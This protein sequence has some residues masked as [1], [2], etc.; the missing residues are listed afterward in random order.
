MISIKIL[1]NIPFIWVLV[2]L[3]VL[4]LISGEFG[5]ILGRRTRT[6]LSDSKSIRI[7][8]TVTATLALLGF[9]FALTFSSVVGNM[10][11]RKQLVLEEANAIGTAYL[12]ADLLNAQDRD[13]IKKQLYE[14]LILRIEIVQNYENAR[15]P[16]VLLASENLQH[17]LWQ[18]AVESA[19]NNPTSVESLFLQSVNEVIDLHQMRIAVNYYHRMPNILWVSLLGL[20]IL[21][22]VVGGYD[23]GL[24]GGKRSATVILSF[25]LAFSLILALIVVLDRPGN[26]ISTVT[27]NALIDAQS[28]IE[29]TLK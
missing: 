3:L 24:T 2:S 14:Y 16:E 28:Q 4:V 15:V 10:D 5:F 1:D 19:G 11:E 17:Q 27:Q 12:R 18:T 23:A 21:A 8:P 13:Q 22:M 7:G 26:L 29:R 25:S 6:R 9:M 20:T